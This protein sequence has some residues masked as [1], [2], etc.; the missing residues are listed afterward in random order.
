MKTNI[1]V[2]HQAF[3]NMEG[4]DRE[5]VNGMI[6]DRIEASVSQLTCV[7]SN[8]CKCLPIPFTYR[9][10]VSNC[11]A[12]IFYLQQMEE[13]TSQC[14]PFYLNITLLRLKQSKVKVHILKN[15]RI[16][17]RFL[18]IIHCSNNSVT[19]EKCIIMGYVHTKTNVSI[20]LD[21]DL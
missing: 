5:N 2:D 19:S 8:I 20:F 18:K 15:K 12:V 13:N 4:C 11:T 1:H 16:N 10:V 21:Q 6:I 9:Y 3:Y 17:C 7:T 14:T